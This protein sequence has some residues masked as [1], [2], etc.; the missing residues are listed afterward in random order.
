MK[1]VGANKINIATDTKIKS[2]PHHNMERVVLATLLWE[3]IIAFIL[4]AS[5]YAE[6]DVSEPSAV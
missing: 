1:S 4:F 3:G 2:I 5:S 6:V